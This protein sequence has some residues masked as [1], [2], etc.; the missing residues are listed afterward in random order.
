MINDDEKR[1]AKDKVFSQFHG[2]LIDLAKLLFKLGFNPLCQNSNG[3]YPI[4]YAIEFENWPLVNFLL[5][6]AKDGN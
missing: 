4:H 6:I 5:S 2:Y 3:I 1:K